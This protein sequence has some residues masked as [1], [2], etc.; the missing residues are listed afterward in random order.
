MGLIAT[1]NPGALD[2]GG[3]L[4]CCTSQPFKIDGTPTAPT[5]LINGFPALLD[6][7]VLTPAP[8]QNPCTVIPSPCANERSVLATSTKVMIGGKRVALLNDVLNEAAAITYAGP[9]A[10]TVQAV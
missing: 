1:Y 4:P 3:K 5:V 9:G 10:T 7:D 8:G 6:Q 2:S